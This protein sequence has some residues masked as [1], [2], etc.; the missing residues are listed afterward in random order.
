[1]S[2]INNMN[3]NWDGHSHLEVEQFIKETFST[4]VNAEQGKGLS[5]EDFSTAEKAKLASIASGAQANVIE[6][7]RVNG[8]SMAVAG[9]A[10][11]IPVPA[12]LEELPGDEHHR[13]VSDDEKAAWN[14]KYDKPAGGIPKSDLAQAVQTS[15]GKADTAI[16][17]HQDISNLATKEEIPVSVSELTEDSTHRTVTDA[18]KTTWTAK[19]DAI[20]DLDTIRNGAAAGAT[21]YQVPVTGIPASELSNAVQASLGKADTAIQ[22]HQSLAGLTASVQYDSQAKRIRFYDNAGTELV[23]SIDATDFIKDGMIDDV[24]IS[25]GQLVISFNTDAGKQNISIALTD[26]FDPSNYYDKTASDTALAGKTDK[27]LIGSSGTA[28]MFNETDGGGAKFEHLDGSESFVGVNDGGQNGLMAQIYADKL[29]NGAWQ[30]AKLDVTNRGIFYTVGSDRFADRAVA[31]NELAVKGD[32][33]T[34]VA[35]LTEDATHRTVTDTEKAT[36]NGKQDAVADLSDIRSGAAAGATAYQKP[37]KGIPASDLASAVQTSLDKADTALQQHQ[38]LD[39]YYTKSEVDTAVAGAESNWIKDGSSNVKLSS[40]SQFIGTTG[41]CV[42]EGNNGTIGSQSESVANA[43]TEGNN[44][45]AAA[46]QAHA[47][48]YY[49]EASGYHAHAEGRRTIASGAGAHSEGSAADNSSITASGQ[50]A[51]AEGYAQNAESAIVASGKGSHAEGVGTT[52]VND[53]EHAEGRYN[54]SVS[55][56]TLSSVGFGTSASKK[57][58]LEVDLDGTAYVKGVGTFD[59]TNSTPGTNDVA[60]VI[61][62]K[63]DTLESGRNIKT[64]NNQSILGG[65]NI[66]ISGVGSGNWTDKGA[67]SVEMN[68]S[69]AL[70]SEPAASNQLGAVAAGYKTYANKRYSSSKGQMT[71]A[72]VCTGDNPNTNN[73]KRWFKN[74]DVITSVPFKTD[75]EGSRSIPE[76]TIGDIGVGASAE[77]VYST[78]FGNN[79]HAEGNDTVALNSGTHAEGYHTIALGQQSHAEGNRTDAWGN[80]AHSEGKFTRASGEGAHAEGVGTSTSNPNLASGKGAHAEGSNTKATG[81]GAHAEGYYSYAKGQASHAEGQSIA[82]GGSAHSEGFYSRAYGN[83]AHA[84]GWRSIAEGNLTHVEGSGIAFSGHAEAGISFGGHCESD[85]WGCTF[86]HAHAEGADCMA[87]GAWSHAEG[88]KTKAGGYA[89]TGYF[90]DG[91][92]TPGKLTYVRTEVSDS[93]ETDEQGNAYKVYR[94]LWADGNG[95]IY[96]YRGG[97]D[98]K[99]GIYFPDKDESCYFDPS[100]DSSLPV[101]FCYNGYSYGNYSHAEGNLNVFHY[102]SKTNY[103]GN[104]LHAVGVGS[105]Y[106]G[107]NKNGFEIMENGDT[108]VLGIGGYDGTNAAASGVKTLQTVISEITTWIAQQNGGAIAN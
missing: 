72:G 62:G 21:A 41:R 104:T 52:A 18:E 77:G 4:K 28:L 3:E 5:T 42:A 73:Y 107:H 31:A 92:D 80:Q 26:I 70:A 86:G 95:N 8:S 25:E 37:A 24:Q 93:A 89:V 68:E 76:T 106:Y 33:P 9:N 98:R 102:A 67:S 103:S 10:V 32:L 57:N 84:E 27:R 58:A 49:S 54:K 74:G 81:E 51:H 97:S 40:S 29:V 60:T 55:G 22:Q 39:N 16:Q 101:F 87:L 47:E 36:W 14:A 64:I 105:A 34:T 48:G 17:E 82:T 19:Q 91:N 45:T 6:D 12:A 7:V 100:E 96:V 94:N 11:D 69:T 1:M 50:G 38:S 79:A 75:N 56:K 71:V 65:G 59:G 78:A 15:L 61:A 90:Q 20:S 43:H 2:R 30:G 44:C 66:N 83:Y 108:Y 63:Q 46:N 88:F 99:A 23:S 13:L 53:G 35:E 85:G